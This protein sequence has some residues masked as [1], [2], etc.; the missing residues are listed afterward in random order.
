[1]TSKKIIT[2]FGATGLQGGAVVSTF[3][4]DPAL[5]NEW[6]VRGVTR[7]VSKDSALELARKGVEVVSADLDDKASLVEAMKRSHTVFGMTNYWEKGDMQREIQ[8]G[9]NLADA[10]KEAGVQHYVWSCVYSATKLSGGKLADCYHFDSKAEVAE[11]VESLGIPASFFLPG[12]YM[13]NLPGEMFRLLPDGTYA[14]CLP[15]A[16]TTPF[17][18]YDTRDTGIYVKAIVVNRE[19]LL[20]KRLLGATA[21]MTGDEIVAGFAKVFPEAGRTARYVDVP[22]ATY[23]SEMKSKGVP[24]YMTEEL[25][26]NFRLMQDFGYY[27]GESLDGTHQLIDSPLTTW[28][29]HAKNA[30]A[31]A[32]LK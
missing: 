21:Y 15:V 8:Q 10:A 32:H 23:R 31:W 9:K 7:N 24:D 16:S 30:K 17:P 11:Y 13:S 20:G 14:F 6:A 22:E 25:F 19:K 3:L 4:N 18:M 2:V 26:Q 5:K 12:F 27:G 29:E 28:E 1:M